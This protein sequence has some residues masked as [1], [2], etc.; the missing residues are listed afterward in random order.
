MNIITLFTKKKSYKTVLIIELTF[1]AYNLNAQTFFYDDFNY[2]NFEVLTEMSKNK[3]KNLW[4]Y[5]KDIWKEKKKILKKKNEWKQAKQEWKLNKKRLKGFNT[6]WETEFAISEVDISNDGTINDEEIFKSTQI[7][8]DPRDPNNKIIQFNLERVDPYF[9][10]KYK[11][12]DRKTQNII[13][14]REIKKSY[15]PEI[16]SY[17]TGCR[18][19]LLKEYR[20]EWRNHMV[21]NEISTWNG[22]E[23]DFYKPYENY[24]F[25]LMTF[26]H[27]LYEFD[28][29]ENYDIITQFHRNE[30]KGKPPIAL[31]IKNKQ[32]FLAITNN[33]ENN[34]TYYDLGKVETEKW[35]DWVFKI[36]L[37]EHEDGYVSV[38][39]NGEKI[40][41]IYGKNANAYLNYYL[42]I[43]IYKSAWWDCS[44]PKSSS[45]RKVISYD[46]VWAKKSNIW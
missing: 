23:K 6:V 1:L 16:D 19:S 7:I 11:C 14:D 24:T 25:G 26:I 33:E 43:G 37:S 22:K 21:R 35:I 5:D 30:G 4:R 9:F 18:F 46:K 42:K 34:T 10:T 31:V 32:Y 38:Y 45:R 12:S 28:S 29:T 20:Y 27:D 44:K 39:K 3:N 15:N 17:C 36:K 41:E 13:S 40:S 8:S 2:P